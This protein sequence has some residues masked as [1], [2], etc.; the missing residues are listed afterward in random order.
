MFATTLG[1]AACLLLAGSALG[2]A[3]NAAR[4]DGVRFTKFAPPNSCGAEAAPAGGGAPV[5]V[6]RPTDV[7]ALCNDADTLLADVR[8]P[9]EFAEG[10]VTGAMHLPCTSSGQAAS[11]AVDRLAGRH[12]LIVYG[13]GTDDAKVVADEL[14]GRASRAGRTDL[15]VLVIEGGFEA[16]NHAGLA[17]SSGPCPE[18][19]APRGG[20][21]RK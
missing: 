6:L 12:T 9:A 5:T 1:R 3:V 19:G 21:A 20:A 8:P 17:C 2:L 18:C 16:W 7:V 13:D 4:P 14:R 15:R 11:A 10:H